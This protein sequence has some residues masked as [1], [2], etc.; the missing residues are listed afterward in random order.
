MKQNGESEVVRNEIKTQKKL[1]HSHIIRLYEAF[2]DEKN[3]YMVFEYA[4]N[5][6]LKQYLNQKKKLKEKEAFVFVFQTCLA[7]DYLHKKSIVHSDINV[8]QI[9]FDFLL[10]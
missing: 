10:S 7:L 4:K 3:I 1:N 5:G 2:E 9:F 8:L 6:T